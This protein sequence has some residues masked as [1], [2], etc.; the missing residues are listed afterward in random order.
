MNTKRI[1]VFA[2][3]PDD[4]TFGCGGTIVKKIREGCDV[5]VVVMTDGRYAFLG[6]FGIHSN[7]TPEELKEI[8]INELKRA[9]KILGIPKNNLV[10]LDF[11][12]G[13]LEDNKEEA[14]EKIAAILRENCPDAVYIPY[15]QDGHPDHRATYKIVKNAIGKLKIS[16]VCY[17]YS[18]TSRFER[19]G[20]F[21]DPIL[22][23]FYRVKRLYVD[24]SD[25]LHIKRNAITEFRSELMAISARQPKPVIPN[26][27]K[28]QKSKEM[29][30]IEKNCCKV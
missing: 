19:F 6:L 4:E 30:R 10:F 1:L 18:I 11:V 15:R 3:H 14:V 8:R 29:F 13:T 22:D 24:I 25:V 26:S 27:E 28:F 23:F 7:P 21:I 2:P 16:P 12:D 9:T 5:H 20:Y 17:Q